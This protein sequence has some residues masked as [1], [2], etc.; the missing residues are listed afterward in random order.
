MSHQA[1]QPFVEIVLK[2]DG[3]DPLR[4]TFAVPG[5]G[6]RPFHGWVG[7]ASALLALD[8]RPAGSLAAEPSPAAKPSGLGVDQ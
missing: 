2:I 7:L 1:P 6:E 4:G 3:W 8:P 5:A